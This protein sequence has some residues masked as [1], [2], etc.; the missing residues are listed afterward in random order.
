MD[1]DDGTDRKNPIKRG[2]EVSNGCIKGSKAYH[3]LHGSNYKVVLNSSRNC[4]VSVIDK[5]TNTWVFRL[6]K[7]HPGAEFNHI[8]INTKFSKLPHDP[9]IP[10]PPGG[11]TVS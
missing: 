2:F 1:N 3:T 7:A 4:K 5:A 8:N 10:L 6:D 11:L 9:H